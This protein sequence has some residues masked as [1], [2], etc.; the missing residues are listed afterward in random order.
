MTDVPPGRDRDVARVDAPSER[1]LPSRY[2]PGEPGLLEAGVY[3]SRPLRG[4]RDAVFDALGSPSREDVGRGLDTDPLWRDPVLWARL[5]HAVGH[6]ARRC[7][8]DRIVAADPDV[9]PLASAVAERLVLPL[10][11]R[12][13]A[14]GQGGG[15]RAAY[16]VARVLHETKDGR[17]FSGEGR[18]GRRPPE[19]AS[20]AGALFRIR[21]S[22]AG[23]TSTRKIL[24]I[25]DL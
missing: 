9:L 14:G 2:R 1:H 7:G 3:G 19:G 11:R 13:G 16:L 15:H 12:Q 8:A 18:G 20:G 22:D 24:H 21:A 6:H 23:D 5:A 10:E 17:S 25:I 4:L